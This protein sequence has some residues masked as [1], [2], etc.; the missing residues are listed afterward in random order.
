MFPARMNHEIRTPVTAVPSLLAEEPL[1]ERQ[2]GP[3]HAIRTSGRHLL[4]LI[5]DVLDLSRIE[6]DG[7]A[8]EEIAYSMG[9]PLQDS[10]PVLRDDP[11]RLRK[12]LV[13]LVGNRPKFASKGGVRVD[14]G[15]QGLPADEVRFRLEAEGS[16]IGI[17]EDR[18]AGPSTTRR[19]GGLG[20][21]ICRRLAAAMNGTIGVESNLGQGSTFW[22]EV[23]FKLGSTS[24]RASGAL[25]G[26]WH[27]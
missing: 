26:S 20:L 18:Q 15:W 2:Q 13:N 24:W 5:N 9:E 23:S 21:T 1:D 11:A 22:F 4:S 3:V 12:V 19:Y 10:P 27:A 7:L 14:V 16:G 17:P 8:L 25:S 6:A